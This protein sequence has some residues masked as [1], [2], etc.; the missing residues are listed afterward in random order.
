[1][2]KAPDAIH[3]LT[4]IMAWG[5]SALIALLAPA[6]FFVVSYEYLR[7]ELEAHAELRSHDI[8]NIIHQNPTMWQYEEI[9]L[10]ELIEPAASSDDAAD[11]IRITDDRGAPLAQNHIARK[12]PSITH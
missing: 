5:L 8:S 6:F 9:R 12:F 2:K 4:L 11:F 3:R 1:M 10:S 7:G